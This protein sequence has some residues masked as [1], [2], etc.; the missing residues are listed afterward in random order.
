LAHAIGGRMDVERTAL[1]ACGWSARRATLK[2]ANDAADEH[3]VEG[4]EGCDHTVTIYATGDD[5][6]TLHRRVERRM[7]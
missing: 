5:D 4:C 2:A 6:A 7:A 1:C 3:V